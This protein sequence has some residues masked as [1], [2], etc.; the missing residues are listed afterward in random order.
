MVERH[1]YALG[2]DFGTQSARSVLVDIRTGE[3]LEGILYQY[4]HG[5]IDRVLPG[6]D[7]PVGPDA[8]LQDP[9]DYRA[10]LELLLKETWKKANVAPEA[11]RAIG[12]DFTSCTMFPVDEKM[13]PLCEKSAYRDDPQSWV[14]LWKHHGGQAQANRIRQ[15][16][17]ARGEK[18]L[19]R[20]GD[21][22]SSEWY[23][24][25]LLETYEKA[26]EI[27]RAA[28]RFAN[29]SDWV[30]YLMTGEVA[31]SVGAAGFH[32]F[33]SEETG[34]PSEA[35]LEA[36][37]PGFGN[38]LKEKLGERILPM[39]GVFG[40]LT[41]EMA[42]KTGLPV[43][44]PVCT[45]IIDAHAALPAVG[46]KDSGEMLMSLG[47][48]LCHIM[49]SKERKQVNGICGV[50]KN[51]IYPG[52]YGYEAGQTAGGDIYEWFVRNLVD[53]KLEKEAAEAGETV[54]DC[55]T[56]KAQSLQVGQSG[57]MALDWWNGNRCVLGSAELSGLLMGMTLNTRPEEIYRALVEATAYGTRT[58]LENYERG[59]V[60]VEKLY[61]C[62]GLARKS[63]LVMQIFA[64]V[65]GRE[66][67][68]SDRTQAAAYG[69]AMHAMVA[70][71]REKG[72]YD[73]IEEAVSQLIKPATKCWKPIWENHEKYN[74]L[75]DIYSRLH[76]LLG[77]EEPQLMRRLRE[78]KT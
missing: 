75:F 3:E 21:Q 39:C 66:I 28:Y 50:V 40:Y 60:M 16:A 31:T 18:L 43:G 19:E 22:S 73:T 42:E 9:A 63:E 54:F 48:S 34:Y 65:L 26:P 62:G 1:E 38:A 13:Q 7:I 27:Y 5:V 71:G 32:G 64:D 24:P 4:P 78:L 55:L 12:V 20:Y 51:G 33:W 11:V 15:V 68:V 49:V 23:L 67:Y 44:I 14:K 25:K 72:G 30:C 53:S 46:V 6:T 37:A 8:A 61:A 41:G 45:P 76:D 74:E 56:R 47:T 2:I 10:G 57:L 69:A 36:L 35:F 52:S 29:A 59:G 70:L 77:R 58:I 17:D